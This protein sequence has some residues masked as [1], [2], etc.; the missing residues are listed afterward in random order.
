MEPADISL[1]PSCWRQRCATPLG[2][3]TR[4][5][6]CV[7][8]SVCLSVCS[9]RQR[10]IS[11]ALPVGRPTRRRRPT[12]EASGVT[13]TRRARADG[14]AAALG[15]NTCVPDDANGSQAGPVFAHCNSAR[16]CC[17]TTCAASTKGRPRDE[18]TKGRARSHAFLRS[19]SLIIKTGGRLAKQC[20]SCVQFLAR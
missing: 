9:A 6:A 4:M 11:L 2:R 19:R 16:R 8:P 3:R 7:R 1:R 13:A 12:I 18:Q 17:A 20:K 15:Q 14:E 10:L 5:R